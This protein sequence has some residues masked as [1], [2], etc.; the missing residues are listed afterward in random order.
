[1]NQ[2]GFIQL[3]LMAWGAIGVG[4]VILGLGIALKVQSARLES[5]KVEYAAFVAQVKV[6]GEEAQRKAKAKETADLKAKEKSN[7][8]NAKLRIDNTALARRL[9]DA[10][11]GSRFVPPAAASTR[12][13]NRACFDR[14]EL[15]R[16]LQRLDD[17]I[18]S[19]VAE[20]DAARID[21]DTAKR[22]VSETR[23]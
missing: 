8:D 2:R 14:A 18:S 1:M 9:R 3:P 21:L 4:L 7:A 19:I 10:R 5:C 13:P 12:E 16:T 20:G 17:E 15:E 6:L 23:Q 22:W 11:A